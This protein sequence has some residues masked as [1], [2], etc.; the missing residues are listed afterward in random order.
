MGTVT[1]ICDALE[2][3]EKQALE[4]WMSKN[5]RFAACANTM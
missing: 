1:S 4:E 5:K 3:V 2:P